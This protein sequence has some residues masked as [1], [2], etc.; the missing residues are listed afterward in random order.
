MTSSYNDKI[1][2]SGGFSESDVQKDLTQFKRFL[3]GEI[4]SIMLADT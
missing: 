4:V 2:T 1:I 3:S